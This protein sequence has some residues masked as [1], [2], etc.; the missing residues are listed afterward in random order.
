MPFPLGHAI[1]GYSFAAAS[2]IRFRRDLWTAVLFSLV[3]AN[4][5]DIDFLPGVLRDTPALYHRTVTHTLLGAIVCAVII[6]TLLTR[7]RGRFGQ[8]ALISFLVYASHLLADMIDLG[9]GNIGVRLFWPITDSSYRILTPYSD[10][11]RSPFAFDRGHGT[12]GFTQSLL[13]WPFLRVMLLQALL[14]L[15]LVP[16]GQLIRRW[17]SR[18]GA[19]V[20]DRRK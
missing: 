13:S 16:L 8:I 7:F 18:D 12:S 4:L 6:A 3:V 19:E 20:S 5:P 11:A 2:G 17:R 15:P 10:L 1:V 14:F 9:G